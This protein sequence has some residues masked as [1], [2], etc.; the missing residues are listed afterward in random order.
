[1]KIEDFRKLQER[2]GYNAGINQSEEYFRSVVLVLLIPID[3]V[4]HFVFQKRCR[5]I[6]Q[7]GELCFPG[8]RIDETDQSLE[9]TA[10]RETTEE[11]GIPKDKI[12][13]IG[14]LNTIVAPMGTIIDA[15]VGIADVRKEELLLNPKE[16]EKVITL[17]VSY[18]MEHD[19][20]R[21][22]A[23]VHVSPTHVDQET[24]EELI[25]LP[26]QELGLPDTYQKPWGGFRYSIPVYK[27]PDE[28]LWG[29]T[30]RLVED[31]I[32]RIKTKG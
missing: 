21:Y 29:I 30:A 10:I 9:E 23:E 31:F 13:I 19:P 7:G 5:N 32:A 20:E 15:F 17:P 8:G 25:L 3:E 12:E 18:F 2:I 16:V 27:L 28:I 14:R 26:S 24:G 1:M 6:R 11:L 22:R 4:Y